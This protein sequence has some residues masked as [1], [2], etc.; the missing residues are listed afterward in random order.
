MD[1][2]PPLDTTS[3]IVVVDDH[4]LMRCALRLTLST[5]ADLEVVGEAADGQQAVELCRRL[6]PDLVLMDVRM[7]GMDGLEAT[8]QKRGSCLVRSYWS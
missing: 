8:R 5:Q 2:K 4:P 7:P 6:H 1:Q 3:R